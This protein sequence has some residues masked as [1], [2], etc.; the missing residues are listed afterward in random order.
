[1]RNVLEDS[2]LE[3]LDPYQELKMR[4]SQPLL[5]QFVSFLLYAACGVLMFML[6]Q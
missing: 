2:V 4:I 1:M 5:L 6:G 3:E